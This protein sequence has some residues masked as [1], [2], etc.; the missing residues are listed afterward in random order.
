MAKA[1]GRA[2][3]RALAVGRDRPRAR[4]S[5]SPKAS[6]SGPRK[7]EPAK[8]AA[9][10]QEPS[11]ASESASLK[12]QL[13]AARLQTREALERQ[14]ATADI[15]K[16]IASSPSDLQPVFNAVVLTARRLLRREMAFILLC[17]DDA[18]FRPVAITGAEGLVQILNPTPIPVDPEANFPSRAIVS[19][20][21]QQFPD[22]SVIDLPDEERKIRE[23]Y[24]L[25]S[26][27]YL[28][29]L[30]GGECI[31]VLG[32]GGR[33]A[34]SFSDADVALAESFRDQ[35]VIAIENARLFNETQETLER[36]T[37]TADILKVIASSPSDAQPVFEAIVTS[38][39][40]LIGGLTAG[41]Y[42]FVDGVAHLVT[43]T[44]LNPAADEALRAAFP[45]PI[46]DIEHFRLAAAGE[47]LQIADT[48]EQPDTPLKEVGRS[49][50][51]RSILF[52]PLNSHGG[53]IGTLTVTRRD[54][55][56]FSTHHVQLLQTFADQAVIAI[57]NTRLFNETKEALE[58]QT[59]TAEIL[60][61]IA[62]S[63]DN[64][65]PVFDAISD[66]AKTLCSG[67]VSGVT[68][69][70]GE[71]V[72]YAA[73]RGVSPDAEKAMR[74]GFPM[75]P[76]GASIAA[77]AI[78]AGEPV[79]IHDVDL[80]PDYGADL[81]K[82]AKLAGYRSLMGVPI[83]RDGRVIGA[84]TVNRAETGSFPDKQVKLLQTFADQAVIAIENV[85]LFNETKEAL[86][87]Q[88]A[89]ADILRVISSSP[90]DVQPVF[91]AIVASL[92][93]LFGT[94]FA[95]VQLLRAG[96]VT[97]PAVG[98]KPGFE[99]LAE[100]FPRPLDDT[101]IGGLVM[102]SKQTQQFVALEDPATPAGTQRFARD[103][104]FN[105]VLFTHMIHD[106]QVIG[107]I[108]TAHPDAKVFDPHQIALME[109]F[110]DQAVIA[111][112]NVRLL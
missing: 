89:S 59:A 43:F 47:V 52:V 9:P 55:G 26:A 108:G 84:V 65:Q 110:A 8:S 31:G 88:T 53:T 63:P 12:R 58:R 40:R 20:T 2:G 61:V 85:R 3:K 105:S 91:D 29:M 95:A 67:I 45:R 36:Q 66:R 24:G 93:R 46:A 22:W 79:Q 49:R 18:T 77:R 71:W 96:S 106:G 98:G 111:I 68:R 7:P 64:V 97:M 74:K 15:L 87:R 100:R 112:S 42:R 19:K 25:S 60:K 70:D 21:N 90:T 78:R 81:K 17:G 33:Q 73:F 34:R 107:S 62:S 104:G 13:K 30:R 94:Q 1:R 28:P 38:A 10:K 16:V 57:E 101:T 27:L 99:R 5:G 35:A 44:P 50:G 82:A 48:E 69:F 86:Q 41:A 109:L 75:R 32:L 83:L 102:M 4:K 54:P 23:M 14:T 56:P 80:D 92:L 51:Y 37:A 11:V 103:F 39:K 72:H 6:R 76:G